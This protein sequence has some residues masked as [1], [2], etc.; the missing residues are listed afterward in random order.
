MQGKV[1][2][3]V[4]TIRIRKLSCCQDSSVHLL[5]EQDLCCLGFLL[6]RLFPDMKHDATDRCMRGFILVSNR[7][8]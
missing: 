7:T 8:K 2:V 1:D 5:L 6:S 4:H 3:Q